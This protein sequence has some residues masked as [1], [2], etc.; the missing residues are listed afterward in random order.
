MSFMEPRS[1]INICNKALSRIGQ[2]QLSGT[3]DA[4]TGPNNNASREC[5]LHYKG[6]VRAVLEAH[7][8]NMATRRQSLVEVVNE[9]SLEW[10]FAYAAPADMAFPVSMHTPGSETIGPVAYYRGIGGLIAKLYGRPY[11]TYSGNVLYSVLGPAEVE[12]TSFNISEQDFTQ[13]I[14]DVIVLYL[15][16]KLAYSLA[17]DTKLGNEIKQEAI[18]QMDAAIARNLNQQQPRYDQVPS[19]AELARA[20]I[21]PWMAGYGF[22]M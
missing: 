17:K 8:W 7:H 1:D 4:P 11:F 9:R 3:L 5:R 12:Y 13:E 14:E 15:A 6:V 22:A 16:A 18:N 20:G 19:E 10:P 2:T 21:D